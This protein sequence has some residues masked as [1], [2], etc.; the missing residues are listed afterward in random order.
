MIIDHIF[1]P[2]RIQKVLY[3]DNKKTSCTWTSFGCMLLSW[4]L[5]ALL[6]KCMFYFEK[7]GFCLANLVNVLNSC[8]SQTSQFLLHLYSKQLR[9]PFHSFSPF[10]LTLSLISFAFS[11]SPL[12]QPTATVIVWFF[13]CYIAIP[14]AIAAVVC[15][16]VIYSMCVIIG[17]HRLNNRRELMKLKLKHIVNHFGWS[18]NRGEMCKS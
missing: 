15:L 9:A 10:S 8:E 6:R 11:M 4:I 16:C 1:Q 2:F 13:S 14:P 3:I 12:S 18:L 7:G 5:N 17:V